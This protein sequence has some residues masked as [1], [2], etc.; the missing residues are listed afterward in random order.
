MDTTLHSI[1]RALI[2]KAMDRTLISWRAMLLDLTGLASRS[3]VMDRSI[4]SVPSLGMQGFTSRTADCIRFLVVDELHGSEVLRTHGTSLDG[5]RDSDPVL[6]TT[7]HFLRIRIASIRQ[8]FEFVDFEHFLCCD[9]HWMQQLA[10]IGFVCDVIVNN[11]AASNVDDTLKIIGRELWCPAV[12]HWSSIR[13]TEDHDIR[14]V[15]CEFG[16]PP[17]QPL[18]ASLKRGNRGGKSHTIGCLIAPVLCMFICYI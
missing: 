18:F 8:H 15:I 6:F 14:I 9:R 5:R 4:S 13:L 17:L 1:E 3:S 16:L 12:A 2:Y 10:V 7:S 11:Q